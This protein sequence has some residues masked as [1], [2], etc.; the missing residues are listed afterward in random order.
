MQSELPI[1][2][3]NK[4]KIKTSPSTSYKI[5][6]WMNHKRRTHIGQMRKNVPWR[7]C[8]SHFDCFV[9]MWLAHHHEYAL[10]AALCS[11]SQFQSLKRWRNTFNALKKKN[12]WWSRLKVKIIIIIITQEKKRRESYLLLYR[13]HKI[14][15]TDD[16]NEADMEGRIFRP[17]LLEHPL[18]NPIDCQLG[19]MLT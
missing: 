5:N 15:C 1:K 18:K 12:R 10:V 13:K 6:K 14:F 4:R 2:K 9:L 7:F 17:G 11:I 8:S 3:R 16:W 19:K